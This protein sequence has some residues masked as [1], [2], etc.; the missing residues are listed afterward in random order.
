MCFF[1]PLTTNPISEGAIPNALA[2]GDEKFLGLDMEVKVLD[3]RLP[4][5][6]TVLKTQKDPLGI[7][8]LRDTIINGEKV[9]YDY[10]I[11]PV[12]D[13]LKSTYKVTGQ[14]EVPRKIS[15]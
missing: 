5:F 9:K 10:V 14:G 12:P 15:N 6:R 11:E 3:D 2:P 7:L 4:I 8:Y 1:L 13:T